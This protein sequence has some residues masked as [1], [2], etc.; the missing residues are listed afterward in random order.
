MGMKLKEGRLPVTVGEVLR[1]VYHEDDCV[2]VPDEQ[3]FGWVLASECSVA[4]GA[5]E[6]SV[7]LLSEDQ[8]YAAIDSGGDMTRKLSAFDVG[9][10]GFRVIGEPEKKRNRKQEMRRFKKLC[11][12]EACQGLILFAGW[13]IMLRSEGFDPRPV[14]S[15]PFRRDEDQPGDDST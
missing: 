11:R 6:L 2:T 13:Y 14:M 7:K 9:F 1:L 8:L 3:G 4:D 15:A 5:W 10:A 12:A